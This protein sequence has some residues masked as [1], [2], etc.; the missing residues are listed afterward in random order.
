MA[1]G[2]TAELLVAKTFLKLAALLAALAFEFG[3]VTVE[4]NNRLPSCK[5][6]RAHVVAP[7]AFEST[8]ALKSLC[9]CA[10]KV[11]TVNAG[12]VAEKATLMI[13]V[14]E[15]GVVDEGD[16]TGLGLGVAIESDSPGAKH[17]LVFIPH[18]RPTA[19][20]DCAVQAPVWFTVPGAVHTWLVQVALRVMQS[21]AVLQV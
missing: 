10:W 20:S 6:L 14:G 9:C 15:V 12:K 11:A 3:K 18:V 19:Q 1:E 16:E 5:L 13:L 4:S 17:V 2:K 8:A 7:I 21:E